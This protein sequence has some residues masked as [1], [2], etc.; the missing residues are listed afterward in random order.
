MNS[1]FALSMHILTI[2]ASS[3]GLLTSERLAEM[4]GTNAAVIRRLAQ[5]L[6][7][8]QMVQSRLGPG[9]GLK[10]GLA[11]EKITL[12]CVF[13][14]TKDETMLKNI[15]RS[16]CDCVFSSALEATINTASGAAEQAFL[17][18]LRQTTLQD[19]LETARQMP[20]PK[21]VA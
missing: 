14:I 4:V 15:D 16:S 8:A 2:L 10:L 20:T 7:K 17:E 19:I 13:A 12:A 5:I 18:T 6:T 3:D 21:A 1:R 9:G 11:P